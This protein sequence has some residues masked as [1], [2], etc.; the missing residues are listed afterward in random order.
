M[1]IFGDKFLGFLGGAYAEVDV[2]ET[3]EIM[4]RILQ[5]D[6]SQF[7]ST[8]APQRTDVYAPQ[9]SIQHAPQII[10]GSPYAGIGAG[11]VQAP[12][13][14]VMPSLVPT[15]SPMQ[16]VPITEAPMSQTAVTEQGN[17]GGGGG[18]LDSALGIG[19]LAIGA[20]VVYFLFFKKKKKRKKK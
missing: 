8:Y 17:G 3:T 18:I 6:M 2:S 7:T 13:V 16:T 5:V 10:L 9:I 19:A 12:M 1:G 15:I 14:T 20:I 11:A 4:N